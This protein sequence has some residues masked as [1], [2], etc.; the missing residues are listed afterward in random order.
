MN[1]EFVRAEQPVL[2]SDNR[3]FRYGEAL[4]ETMKMANGGVQLKRFHFERLFAGLRLLQFVKPASL[5]PG[6]LTEKMM[7]LSKMNGCYGQARIRLTVFRGNGGLA[8]NNSEAQYLIEAMPLDS[9]AGQLNNQGLAIDIFPDA[10]KSCDAFSNLKSA[11]YLPYSMAARFA[12]NNNLEDC[13]ILNHSGNISDSSIANIF[14]FKDG[15]LYTPPLSEGCV[16]GVMRRYLLE[17]LGKNNSGI[18]IKEKE[19]APLELEEADEVFL[20]NAIQ[21]I[22]WVGQYR[23]RKYTNKKIREIINQLPPVEDFE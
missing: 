17:N 18:S 2:M 23:N 8:D 20:T 21:G 19:L 7:Q 6:S 9:T 5:N 10:R 4:F 16:N 1:G 22:R 13:L 11:N 15:V 14:L 3:G 12:S